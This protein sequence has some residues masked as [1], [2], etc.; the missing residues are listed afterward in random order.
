MSNLT[1][2]MKR[3]RKE[4]NWTQ[5]ELARRVGANLSHINRI[6]NEKYVPSVETVIQIADAL[7]VSIDYLV[8]NENG[9]VEE[10]SIEDKPFFEKVELMKRLDEEERT[11]ISKIIDAFLT[12][13]KMLDLLN[14]A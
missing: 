3:L 8:K 12:R 7:E 10:V 5:A 14:P 2:N 6:E 1:A 4:R 9:K 11:I 13:K